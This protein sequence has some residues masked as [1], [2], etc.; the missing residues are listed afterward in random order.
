MS[1][2]LIGGGVVLAIVLAAVAYFMLSGGSYEKG[3]RYIGIETE[4]GKMEVKLY[5]ST[6]QHRDN[7]VKLA[8]EG[9]YDDLLFHRIIPGFM[10]QGGDPESRGADASKPLGQGGPGYTIPAEIGALH[11]KGALSAARTRW[12]RFLP[13]RTLLLS[14]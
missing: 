11:I 6:P 7:M 14:R 9:F 3:Y 1:N 5:N 4:F 13:P 2:K 10:A 8:S 12:R